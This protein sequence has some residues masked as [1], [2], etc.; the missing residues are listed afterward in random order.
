[1]LTVRSGDRRG[2]V[3]IVDDDPAVRGG[4]EFLF[5]VEGYDVRVHASGG[6]FLAAP[7][8]D[9]RVCLII[10]QVMPG[11]TGIEVLRELR[12]RG[13]RPPTI[14]I[15]AFPRTSLQRSATNAGVDM[16]LEKPFFNSELTDAVTE[17]MLG[18]PATC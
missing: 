2:C 18:K 3:I 13:E 16:V 12:R 9:G 14:L 7:P 6:E 10:D 1:M 15:S 11:M 4:L 17:L 8:V 5:L